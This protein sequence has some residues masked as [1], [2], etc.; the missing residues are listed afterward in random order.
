MTLA[1][2]S[3]NIKIFKSEDAFI[4]YLER[5]SSSK[6]YVLVETSPLPKKR[7]NPDCSSLCL[8]DPSW[9]KV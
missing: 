2:K 6:G 9:R 3:D 8:S 7:V 1:D 4:R 5:L